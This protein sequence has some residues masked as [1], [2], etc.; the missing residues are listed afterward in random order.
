MRRCAQSISGCL[1]INVCTFGW[2]IRRIDWSKINT[3]KDFFALLAQ[4]NTYPAEIINSQILAKKKKALVIYG[5]FHFYGA[6]SLRTLVENSHPGAFFLVTPYTGFEEKS[7]SDALE[8]NTRDWPLPAL[9]TPVRGTRLEAPLGASGCHVL[10]LGPNPSEAEKQNREDSEK[11][12]SGISGNGLLYLGPATSL[13]QSARSP[14]I[15]IDLDFSKEIDRRNMI[16][17][18]QS[19]ASFANWKAH[20]SPTFLHSYGDAKQPSEK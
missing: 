5:T 2:A 6:N 7:C 11:Q 12:A 15:Y 14:D 4:R 17:F 9:A 19:P 1:R 3:Q 16:R 13:T 8:Q 18:G 20:D 10:P